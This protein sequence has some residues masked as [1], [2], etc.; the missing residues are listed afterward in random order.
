MATAIWRHV[1]GELRAQPLAAPRWLDASGQ[2]SS[3]RGE[4]AILVAPL[5]RH[6]GAVAAVLVPDAW[7]GRIRLNGSTVV[8]GLLALAHADQLRIDD[9]A[10]WVAGQFVPDETEY[11]PDHHTRDA[12]CFLTKARL[13]DGEPITICPGQPGRTCGLIYK[14]E[15]WR[16]MADNSPKFRCPQCGF[17]PHAEVWRPTPPVVA[18]ESSLLQQLLTGDFQP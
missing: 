17:D 7:H 16:T 4:Q 13:R 12:R 9:A 15:A 2:L 14:R 8:S 18:T 10:F 3:R 11:S 5:E 1:D 6:E